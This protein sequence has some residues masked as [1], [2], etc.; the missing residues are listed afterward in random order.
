MVNNLPFP[1]PGCDAENPSVYPIGISANGEVIYGCRCMVCG[2]CNKHTGN[3]NQGHYW[4]WC[5]VRREM[6][7]FHFCC[8]DDCELENGKEVSLV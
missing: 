1:V 3:S 8:D 2:R 6:L 7:D 5:K 4:A